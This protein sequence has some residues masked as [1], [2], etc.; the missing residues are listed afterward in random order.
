MCL[1]ESDMLTLKLHFLTR[2]YYPGI[3][4]HIPALTQAAGDFGIRDAKQI[5]SLSEQECRRIAARV[6]HYL[7]ESACPARHRDAVA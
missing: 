3:K 5:A 4:Y 6:L 1:F 7:P 2:R